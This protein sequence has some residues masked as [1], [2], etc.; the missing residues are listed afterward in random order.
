MCASLRLAARTRRTL[1]VLSLL[2]LALAVAVVIWPRPGGA[3]AAAQVVKGNDN[4]VDAIAIPEPLPFANEQDNTTATLEP[5]ES[6]PCRNIDNT[7]WYSFTPTQELALKATVSHVEPDLFS[8]AVAV[9]TG[10]N[11]ASLTN[12][13]CGT[14]VQLFAFPGVTY[15]FQVG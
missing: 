9:S 3:P 2:A 10:S 14:I 5:G 12:V 7:V 15:Y 13:G 8:T 1:F 6:Q 11:L 4:F